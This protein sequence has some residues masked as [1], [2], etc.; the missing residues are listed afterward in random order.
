MI[1]EEEKFR[2]ETF[3]MFG[4]ILLTPLGKILIDPLI[5]YQEHGLIYTIIYSMLALVFA[6]IGLVHIEIAR[7]TLDKK[8]KVTWN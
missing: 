3:R 6:Y 5:F 8:D 2:A 7:A 1:S 4:V